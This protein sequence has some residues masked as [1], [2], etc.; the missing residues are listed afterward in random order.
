MDD[1]HDVEKKLDQKKKKLLVFH[2]Q[3]SQ[4]KKKNAKNDKKSR[5]NQKKKNKK[6]IN[7]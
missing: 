2:F 7:K 1:V 3:K 6:C 4:T 5:K